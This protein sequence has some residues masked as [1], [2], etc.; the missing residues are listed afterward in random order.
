MKKILIILGVFALMNCSAFCMSVT[1]K[2]YTVP[3]LKNTLTKYFISN[4]GRIE[5]VSDY[6]MDVRTYNNE[7]LFN[8]LYGSSMN[9][10]PE[11]KTIYNFVKD[12]KNVLLSASSSIIT[13][14]SSSYR[15]STPLSDSKSNKALDQ[16]QKA[17]NGYY[18]FGFA[19]QEHLKYL[20]ILWVIPM[21]NAEKY[22]DTRTRIY[23][24]N[25]IPVMKLT[26]YD[27]ARILHASDSSKII[28]LG[29][30]KNKKRK[31]LE[32]IELKSEFIE[33]TIEKQK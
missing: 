9:T 5:N 3:E 27:L 7:F 21:T 2:N 28:K 8:F 6:S 33:P 20:Q 18:G 26:C 19:Y 11:I 31:E 24:I 16:L 22:L 17:L 10:H 13:N 1:I 30:T 4:G 12:G 25:D 23:E 15:I 14:T 32:T 29:I